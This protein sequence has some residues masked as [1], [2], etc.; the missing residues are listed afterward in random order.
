M[1]VCSFKQEKCLQ[2]S[3]D[4]YMKVKGRER[5]TRLTQT[6]L[7][8]DDVT[9]RPEKMGEYEYKSIEYSVQKKNSSSFQL[10]LWASWQKQSLQQKNNNTIP[11]R[12]PTLQ[13]ES[14]SQAPESLFVLKVS[15]KE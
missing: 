14:E 8:E 15:F 1:A 7:T 13:K 10:S 11:G 12:K 2:T 3:D 6:I 4:F 5:F 9:L